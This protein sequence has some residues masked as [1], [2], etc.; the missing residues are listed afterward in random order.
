MEVKVFDNLLPSGYI[1]AIE[2]DVLRTGFSWFYIKDCTSPHYG[3]NSGF[4]HPAFDHAKEPSD[5][6]PFIKPLV[7]SIEEADGQRISQLYRIRVGLLLPSAEPIGHNTPHVDF[8]WPH[9]TACFYVNDSDGDTVVYKQNLKEIGHDINDDSLKAYVDNTKFD[10]LE[11]VSPVR[12]RLTIFDGF[13][14]HSSTKPKSSDTR[15]VIT[16]NFI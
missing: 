15:I 1:D 14:F 7:Y 9:K 12:N 10:V 16:V 5:W 2:Y 3:S 4:V 6:Y 13:N 11:S 8:L